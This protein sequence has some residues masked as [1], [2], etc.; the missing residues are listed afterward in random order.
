MLKDIAKYFDFII[1]PTTNKI[2]KEEIINGVSIVPFDGSIDVSELE[3]VFSNKNIDA[4]S[5][6]VRS[7]QRKK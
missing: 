2:D 5:L 7:W 6:R 4:N 3:K 1:S